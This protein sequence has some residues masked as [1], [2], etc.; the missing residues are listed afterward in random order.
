MTFDEAAATTA[1]LGLL[2]VSAFAAH[3]R[4]V[5]TPFLP[6][7]SSAPTKL[8]CGLRR[9]AWPHGAI[10]QLGERLDRTQEVGG[11]SPPSSIT[12]ASLLRGFSV[13]WGVLRV[14]L[15]ASI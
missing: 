11:S 10:A 6:G 12:K 7:G 8:D 3:S 5:R 4:R 15:G 13:V 9:S 14:I 2:R 1:D